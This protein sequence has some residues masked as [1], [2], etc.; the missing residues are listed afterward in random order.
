MAL[1]GQMI[2]KLSTRQPS[3]EAR[4]KVLKEIA[5]ENGITLKLEEEEPPAIASEV[6]RLLISRSGD[7]SFGK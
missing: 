4:M 7:L 2:Q 3:L 5:N 6:Q 1:F